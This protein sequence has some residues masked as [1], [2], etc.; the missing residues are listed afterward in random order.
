MSTE[1]FGLL[2]E[3]FIHP[4]T[5]RS[6]GVID[7]PVA[8]ER[9]TAYPYIPGS[10]MKGALR[11]SARNTKLQN[12]DK[13]FGKQENAGELL[14]SDARLL[15]LPVRSL[16]ASYC[17]LTSPYLVERFS[18][19]MERAGNGKP[20]PT[21]TDMPSDDDKI[22]VSGKTGEVLFLE[23]RLFTIER[24]PSDALESAIA[25]LIPCSDTRRRL[26]RQLA[27][28][29]DKTFAWFA[30]YALPVQARNVLDENTK[31]SR[32][33]WYEESLPP[34]TLMY[35]LA[36]ERGGSGAAAELAAHLVG[37]KYLQAGGNE[38]VGEGW[39]TVGRLNGAAR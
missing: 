23:E 28:V 14:I 13:L 36:G 24:G 38:T 5:G 20:V 8:R 26:A 15:L 30:R 12:C 18:R 39:F 19:D 4:G 7:L 2:A 25:A 34:D 10:S 6:E 27:V 22:V 3:T 16:S 29:T 31:T 32:N 35:F 37:Q 17:W 33:L 9:T 21:G 11:D 1:I